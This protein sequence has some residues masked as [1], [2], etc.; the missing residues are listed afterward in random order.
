MI[1]AIPSI[2]QPLD[3]LWDR[4]FG[5][6]GS[7][8][9]DYLSQTSDGGYII[10][11]YTDALNDGDYDI[12]LIRTD[13][14]GNH[15]W[16]RTFGG[17]GWDLGLSVQQTL[18]EGYIVTGNT[19]GE[20]G[21]SDVW[22]IKTDE[23]G[24]LIW[25][26]TFGG[27]YAESGQCVVQL[28]DGG[29][30]IA[31]ITYSLEQSSD[32]WLIK[33][34]AN[35]NE[36]WSQTYGGNDPDYA[37]DVILTDDGGY[38]LTGGTQSFGAGGSDMYMVKTDSEGV[39][40]WS[41]V[42]GGPTDE[43]GRHS[44]CT[45]DGG[46]IVTGSTGQVWNE[47]EADVWLVKTD[48]EGIVVWSQTYGGDDSDRGES[49]Y[50][51][52][53]GGYA[54]A[55]T[56]ATGLLDFAQIWIIRTDPQ[57]NE[58]WSQTYGGSGYETCGSTVWTADDEITVVGNS[59]SIGAGDHDVWL[60]RLEILPLQVLSPNGGEVFR[61]GT[62]RN[63][64]WVSSLEDDIVIEL[65]DG[66]AVERVISAGTPNDDVFEWT[67]PADV[68]PGDNYRIR[69]TLTSGEEQDLSN[70]PFAIAVSPT[71]T[72]TPLAPPIVIPA[73]G[74]GFWYWVEIDNPSPFPGIGQFWT[75]AVLPDGSV[76]GPIDEYQG[77]LGPF[78]TYSP[79]EPFPQ[80][81]PAYAPPGI[82][83]FVM[84]V[85]IYP[86]VIVATDSFPF[87]KLAA[88]NV[89]AL[90]ESEWSVEDWRNDAW[91]LAGAPEI[92]GEAKGE[93]RLLP[94]DYTVSP[95]HP[96]PFNATT[97]ISVSLPESA[98]LMVSIYNVSGQQ[99]AEPAN[100]QF[101]AGSHMLTFDASNLASGLYFVRAT[102]PG[103]FDQVQK[104]M[105][106]R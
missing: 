21:N 103:E 5:G 9:G 2:A 90:S 49:V 105:L 92:D 81:V 99:V 8:V 93:A 98:D 52:T 88:A 71:L 51:T 91:E 80:W 84:H 31:G 46:Y 74:F 15:L 94:T 22:L 53:D 14:H 63:I 62:T 95:A 12:S 59:N 6:L 7:D 85:G 82:Y 102:V 17:L 73:T 61:V 64:E 89:T 76:Y 106:V 69:L 32:V 13:Q 65:M 83:A 28:N 77:A 68:P 50:Q 75:E 25:S 37:Y 48:S 38:L 101:S 54:I 19:P 72:L 42:I 55:G 70:S 97:T 16:S 20:G 45:S 18:D 44:Q 29:Y 24:N 41:Q 104:V 40:Q 86:D 43:G 3:I 66:E 100:G 79:A 56:W 33:T 35:G 26:Q 30:V 67:I 78:S 36:L 39:E 58:I 87:E 34:D 96:N 1:S 27:P 60:V 4:T 11:G 57:G 47:V 23:D 10:V